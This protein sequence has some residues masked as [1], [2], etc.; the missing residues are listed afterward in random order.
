[1]RLRALLVLPFVLAVAAS[2]ALAQDRAPR[3]LNVVTGAPIAYRIGVPRGWDVQRKTNGLTATRRPAVMTFNAIDMVRAATIDPRMTEA[4]ARREMTAIVMGS[5]SATF[6]TMR[7]IMEMGGQA[8]PL[9]DV[10]YEIRTLGGERAGYMTGWSEDPDAPAEF[11]RARWERY[12]TVKD[13]IAYML[14]FIVPD[15]RHEELKPVLGRI[16][17]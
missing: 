7:R 11:A 15:S 4:D 16:V 10:A 14:F 5:D 8:V 1:M 9:R 6:H 12:L 17:D 3:P 2:P 13:G